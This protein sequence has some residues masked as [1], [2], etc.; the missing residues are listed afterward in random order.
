MGLLY[1]LQDI[2]YKVLSAYNNT[3]S[4]HFN[5]MQGAGNSYIYLQ[6]DSPNIDVDTVK[7]LCHPHYGIG[8]DG[9]VLLYPT[10]TA[11]IAMAMYNKDGSR[12]AICGNALRCV[13]KLLYHQSN[14]SSYTV[15]C[16]SGIVT[17]HCIDST[18]YCVHMPTVTIA[19]TI[20]V[21]TNTPLT[22]LTL[23][24]C[25][26]NHAVALSDITS[27]QLCDIMP[28]LDLHYLYGNYNVEVAS[29]IDRCNVSVV[30][31]ERG[32]GITLSCG[33][34]AV[35]TVA[36]L[37]SYNLVDN[38]CHIHMAGGTLTVTHTACGYTLT[39]EAQLVF[40]GD[41]L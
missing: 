21:S 22:S 17:V 23:A 12:G 24:N 2:L 40:T 31:Y 5:K 37:H 35:A 19:N 14:K 10:N 25:G 13:T 20:D 41:I 8:G 18:H 16:D 34:G 38:T 6:T 1:L 36:V 30:V 29:I 15:Q 33:S 28:T 11:N 9:V 27:Q 3:M 4:I 32:S 7:H 39:G 26:N